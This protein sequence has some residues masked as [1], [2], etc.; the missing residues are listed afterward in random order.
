MSSQYTSI[1]GAIASILLCV[2]VTRWL[3]AAYDRRYRS[4]HEKHDQI[5]WGDPSGKSFSDW[6]QRH[7]EQ[8]TPIRLP[9]Q[10]PGR[11]KAN[12]GTHTQAEWIALQRKYSRKCLCCKQVK[13]LTKDHIMP[14]VQGGAD[15]IDNIQPLCQQCNSRKGTRTIDYR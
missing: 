6:K 1:A 10:R 8:P 5:W 9:N 14:V 13:P 11:I 4:F 2:M 12:G 3:I 7:P 15:S